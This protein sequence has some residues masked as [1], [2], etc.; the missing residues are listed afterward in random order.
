M[1]IFRGMPRVFLRVYLPL[2]KILTNF[3]KSITEYNL[4]LIPLK[5]VRVFVIIHCRSI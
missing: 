4:S 2:P 5:F 1:H 3:E